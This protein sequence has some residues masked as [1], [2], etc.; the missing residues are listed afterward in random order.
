MDFRYATLVVSLAEFEAVAITPI[1]RIL[2]V[3]ERRPR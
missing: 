2:S 1:W 3:T